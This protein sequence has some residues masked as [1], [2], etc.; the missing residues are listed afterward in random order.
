MLNHYFHGINTHNY[1]EY[2]STLNPQQ[3]AGQPQ[4]RFDSGFGTTTDSAI[5]LTRLSGNGGGQVAT[6]TFTS[7]Q[8]PAD[9]IDKSACN[10]WTIKFYLVPQASGG[11]YLIGPPPAGYQPAFSDC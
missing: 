4:S 8:S 11:S 9:S 5:T 6:V 3:L 1:Q 7:R 2:A 10:A